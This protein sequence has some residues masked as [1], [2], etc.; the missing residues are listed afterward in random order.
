MFCKLELS[1]SADK[2]DVG[3]EWSQGLLFFLAWEACLE[4]GNNVQFCHARFDMEF[5]YLGIRKVRSIY[6]RKL[7]R[8]KQ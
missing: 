1:G 2:S 6:H 5:Q 7:R 8:R 4:E 3:Y